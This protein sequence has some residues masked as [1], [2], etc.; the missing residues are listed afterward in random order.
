MPF[1][2]IAADVRRDLGESLYQIH[3]ADRL[4][5][6]VTTSS[7]TALKQYAD[8][9][10]LWHQ[11]KFGGCGNAAHALRCRPTRTSPW[12]MPPA[13]EPILV[14]SL[15]SQ[16]RENK[17]TKSAS[18]ALLAHHRPRAHDDPNQLRS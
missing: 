16:S 14:T 5:P 10:A 15:I 11:G 8:G 13:A 18:R 1:D 7:L 6:E 2:V 9:I 3:R 12:P 4:L 17:N